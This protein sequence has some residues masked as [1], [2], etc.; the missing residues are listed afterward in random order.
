MDLLPSKNFGTF[1]TYYL[2]ERYHNE[3]V[4]YLGYNSINRNEYS[5]LTEK[6]N[7]LSKYFGSLF[8][9]VETDT[10]GCSTTGSTEASLLAV[11]NARKKFENTLSCGEND[12]PNVVMNR[13]MHHCWD[14][15]C[16]YLNVEPRYYRS[17]VGVMGE[18]EGDTLNNQLT[19]LIDENTIL[20]VCTEV[21]TVLGDSDDLKFFDSY[22]QD[23]Q[24]QYPHLCMHVDM[25][26][27]GFL[28]KTDLSHIKSV[29]SVNISNHKYGLAYPGCG[30]IIFRCKDW[31]EQSMFQT[32][33]YLK[34]TFHDIGFSFTKSGSHIA[35]QHLLHIHDCE[36]Q[37][38]MDDIMNDVY[39]V[40]AVLY[41]KGIPVILKPQV[42]ILYLKTEIPEVSNLISHLESK[43]YSIPSSNFYCIEKEV[44]MARMVIKYNPFGVISDFLK[45]I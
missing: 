15:V 41:D 19:E 30:W 36:H 39:E 35:S 2:P 9:K 17:H 4:K 12:M 20:L 23:N 45:S 10:F 1:S 44:K 42:P 28:I 3:H 13:N 22:I 25:A 18:V 5:D 31:I 33:S 27:G 32:T 6:E 38:M 14:R 34:G 11:L 21:Y 24:S 29:C 7:E 37:T 26:I 43:G 16:K 40:A 8:F